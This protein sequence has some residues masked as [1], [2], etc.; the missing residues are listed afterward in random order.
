VL[1]TPSTS[2]FVARHDGQ[3]VGVALPLTVTTL[4]GDIGYIEEVVV[5]MR[6]PG[7]AGQ[8]GAHERVAHAGRAEATP[9]R[10]PDLASVQGCGKMPIPPAR[11]RATANQLW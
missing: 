11:F 4:A 8:H 1:G 3:I 7:S 2:S 5:L 6:L 10:G 9:L